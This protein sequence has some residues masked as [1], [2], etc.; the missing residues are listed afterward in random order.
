MTAALAQEEHGGLLVLPD[1]FTVV[2]H[3]AIVTLA[4]LLGL[5]LLAV[6]NSGGVE[7]LVEPVPWRPSTDYR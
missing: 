2:H 6:S 5:G 4:G 1:S 3:D 7:V